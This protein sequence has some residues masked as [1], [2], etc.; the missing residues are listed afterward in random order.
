MESSSSP[1]GG[2]GAAGQT[3]GQMYTHGATAPLGNWF[4]GANSMAADTGVTPRQP[5]RQSPTGGGFDPGYA[6]NARSRQG[7]GATLGRH[8]IGFGTTQT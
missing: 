7:R 8:V 3:Q 5:L 6:T 2:T 1:A 4:P